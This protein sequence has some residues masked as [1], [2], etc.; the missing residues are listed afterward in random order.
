MAHLLFF[1]RQEDFEAA[2]NVLSTSQRYLEVIKAPRFCAGL[3]LPAILLSGHKNELYAELKRK[4][5]A[6]CGLVQHL[7][8]TKRQ[9]D[10]GPPRS[11]W[12]EILG[13]L[14]LESV[15]DSVSD[16]TRLHIEL[17]TQQNFG[18]IIPLMAALIRGGAYNPQEP[19]LAIEEGHRLIAFSPASIVI[20][21]SD[22]VYDFWFQLRC[23][24]ELICEAFE[25]NRFID[26]VQEPRQGIGA[27]EIFRRLPAT[28]CGKCG[29]ATCMEFAVALFTQKAILDLC[30]P[31]LD[32]DMH[33]RRQ[34]LLWVLQ[35]LGL[36]RV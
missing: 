30:T 15:R 23:S 32:H 9:L 3:A 22:D 14:T 35:V 2:L 24:V 16:P 20:S 8:R 17:Q 12:K 31:L 4:K 27:I 33:P 1:S 11:I 10:G 36:H 6:F 19:S 18:A 25:K 5:V 21:R 29:F 13:G 26:P 28:N 34:S 7:H